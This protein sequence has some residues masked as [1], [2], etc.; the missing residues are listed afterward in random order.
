MNARSRTLVFVHRSGFTLVELLVVLAIIGILVALILPAVQ[1][2]RESARRVQCKN[3]LKQIATAFLNHE[4]DHKHYP[5]SGWGYKWVGEPTAGYGKEQPGGWAYN[6]L[7]YMEYD[8]VRESGLT[9]D[10]LLPYY[11]LLS[12]GRDVTELPRSLATALL[13]EFRCP[14]KRALELFP[15]DSD[16]TKDRRTLAENLPNCRFDTGCLVM[17]GD[18]RVNSGSM[19]A[20]DTPG[21]PLFTWSG[22]SWGIPDKSQNGISFQRSTVRHAEVTDG[23]A[24]TALVG[25]KFL[26]SR[27]YVDGTDT[28]D[29]QCL[30]SGHDNDNNGYTADSGAVYRPQLDRPSSVKY[31]FYFGSPHPVGLHMAFCDGSVHLVAF[32]IDD[33]VW[34]HYGGR[35]D[36]A[37]E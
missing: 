24:K 30:M 12:G 7:G 20:R 33:R 10:Q 6:I 1:E 8:S 21:P 32:D 37:P 9:R 35:N 13:P 11:D 4:S 36:H 26:D 28:A 2:S 19:G 3:H 5:T 25:E 16:P 23:T 27:R 31:P 22:S 18:Y 17:R 14:S 15:L 29:D 34:T